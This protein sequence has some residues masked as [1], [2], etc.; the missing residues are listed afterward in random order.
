M[1]RNLLGGSTLLGLFTLFFLAWLVTPTGGAGPEVH[2][3]VLEARD[4][5][6]ERDNPTLRLEPGSRVRLVVRNTDPG[7]LHSIT[8]PGIDDRVRH[9]ESGQETVIEFRVPREGSFDYVCP[10]HAPKMQGRI[11]VD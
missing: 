11:V 7:V 1:K 5:A 9:V 8:L 6:F 3:I 4:L 10:Q 2:E